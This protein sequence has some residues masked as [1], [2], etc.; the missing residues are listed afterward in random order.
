MARLDKVTK[1]KDVDRK[2]LSLVGHGMNAKQMSE[3]LG[4]SR[5]K[6]INVL[7]K[8]GYFWK[9]TPHYGQWVKGGGAEVD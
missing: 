1:T 6:V 7:K 9:G 4:V 2:I 8:N 3:R 5:D